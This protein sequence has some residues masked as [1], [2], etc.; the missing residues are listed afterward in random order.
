[1][2]KLTVAQASDLLA[3]A[4]E[5]QFES[6][7]DGCTKHLDRTALSPMK[8][9]ALAAKHDIPGWTAP[10]ARA[11]VQTGLKGLGYECKLLLVRASDVRSVAHTRPVADISGRATCVFAPLDV[12]VDDCESSLCALGSG[13][14][15]WRVVAPQVGRRMGATPRRVL[16]SRT[17]PSSPAESRPSRTTCTPWAS[18]CVLRSAA[19]H[20]THLKPARQFGISSSA[21]T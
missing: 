9:L 11:V 12:L 17:G 7:V 1:M 15:R 20:T 14:V 5:W 19:P 10:A 18:R 3:L 4:T 2:P 8:R 21:G 6:V 13:T 16:L